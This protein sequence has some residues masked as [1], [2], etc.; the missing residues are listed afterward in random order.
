VKQLV[1]AKSNVTRWWALAGV[2]LLAVAMR[3][4]QLGAQSL[5]MDE[6]KDLS[7]ARGGWAAIS[8]GENRFPP[9]YHS[10][11][12]AWLKIV[13]WDATGRGFSVLCGVLTVAVIAQLGREIGG[14]KAE[15]SAGLLAAIAPFLTWYAVEVRAYSLYIL[16]ASVAIWQ[17][18]AAMETNARRNWLGFAAAAV[19]GVYTH[20][21]CGLLIAICGLSFLV[22]RPAR[23]TLLRGLATFTLVGAACVPAFLLLR[24]DLDQ[25]WGYS[26]T[27]KFS[28]GGL[29]YAYFSLLSGY[30]LGPSV[31]ELHTMGVREAALEVLPWAA[32][33]GLAAVVLLV[34]ALFAR[35][36]DKPVRSVLWFFALC[37]APPLAIGVISR[38]AGFGYSPRH[39]A[40]AAAPLI[41]AL[42]SGIANGRPRSLAWGAGVVVIAAFGVATGN[43]IFVDA[44]RNEDARG[45]AA[46]IAA[47]DF[48]QPTP[49]FALSGYMRD[50]IQFYLAKDWKVFWLPEPAM[51]ATS[52]DPKTL[53]VAQVRNGSQPGGKFWLAYSR[54]FHGDPQGE[55]FK[56]LDEAF[57]IKLEAERAGIR[58]YRGTVNR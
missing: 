28:L 12:A 8:S 2:L 54:E 39:V 49:V 21:Y 31:R 20:Y 7:I 32:P 22:A 34:G 18:T 56:A 17:W 33:L 29:V 44:Y 46:F 3:L 50:P 23:A 36:A 30:T 38:I 15:L 4:S 11:L 40:W 57:S 37:L 42:G 25:S 14:D 24:G 51:A 27:S 13:P 10:L 45:A 9:L 19:A 35:P 16:L 48:D 41:A 1:A 55:I 43:R 52:S 58:I 5:T 26:Q 6:V 53:A 47:A